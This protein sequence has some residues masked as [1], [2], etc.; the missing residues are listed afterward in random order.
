[1]NDKAKPITEKCLTGLASSSFKRELRGEG[2][3]Q[4]HRLHSVLSASDLKPY[5]FRKFVKKERRAYVS[6]DRATL[7]G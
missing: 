6:P 7:D 1:L 2:V 4:P 5:N 3:V